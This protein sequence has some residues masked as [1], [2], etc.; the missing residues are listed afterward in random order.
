M[1]ERDNQGHITQGLKGHSKERRFYS[2]CR[3]AT[4]GLETA[5]WHNLESMYT[6]SFQ[7]LCDNRLQTVREEARRPIWKVQEESQREDD[8]SE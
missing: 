4:G 6:E 5:Q 3:D 7:W 8:D 1:K 2:E